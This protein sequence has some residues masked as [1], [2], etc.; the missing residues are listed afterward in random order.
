MCL[1]VFAYLFTGGSICPKGTVQRESANIMLE[2]QRDGNRTRRSGSGVQVCHSKAPYECLGFLS[3]NQSASGACHLKKIFI[4]QC[5][6]YG[7]D[8]HPKINTKRGSYGGILSM[9]NFFCICRKS[10]EKNDECEKKI[11]GYN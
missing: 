10:K 8:F 5:V 3:P 9:E 6:H 11:V 1:S 2:K 4:G 7:S